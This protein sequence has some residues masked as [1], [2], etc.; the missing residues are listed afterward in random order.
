M[1]VTRLPGVPALKY[2]HLGICDTKSAEC[3]LDNT[4]IR[5]D[6]SLLDPVYS[7]SR[8]LV[9]KRSRMY[10]GR[11]FQDRLRYTTYKPLCLK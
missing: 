1:K 9:S 7:R 2:S 8:V 11:E 3:L 4:H 10:C 6:E 5:P